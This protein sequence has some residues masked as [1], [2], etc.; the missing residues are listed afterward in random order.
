MGLIQIMNYQISYQNPLTHYIDIALQLDNIVDDITYLQLPT[1]RP[2]RYEL[3]NYANNVLKIEVTDSNNKKVLCRKISHS[4][5][6]IATKGL[7]SITVSYSYYAYVMDGGGS[8]LDEEQ[9]YLNFINCMIYAEGQVQKPCIIEFDLPIDY[10]IATSLK[11]TSKHKLQ[12]SSYYELVDSPMI[13]SATLQKLTY[14]YNDTLF[15]IWIK[16]DH[17]ANID[18]LIQDFKLFTSKQF[19]LFG[20]FPFEKYHFLIQ[21]LPY[22]H[23]HGV[24]HQSSTVIT[25]GPGNEF[26]TKKMY[27][28]LVGISSHELF[29]TWNALKIRPKELMP[30]N[31]SKEAYFDTGYVLEGFTTYYGDLILVRSGVLSVKWY[32]NKL[33]MMLRR[34]YENFGR[35][36]MSV[37]ESSIDLWLDGYTAGIPNRKTSIYNE[38]ALFA[39]ILDLKL[40]QLSENQQSLDDVMRLLWKRHGVADTGYSHDDIISIAHEIVPYNWGKF[41]Y[42]HVEGTQPIEQELGT[43]IKSVGCSFTRFESKNHIE[44]RYGFR[45]DDNKVVKIVPSSIAEL[46]LSLDDVILKINGN[47]VEL[48]Q[49]DDNVT[50]ELMRNGKTRKVKLNS[51]ED[52]YFTSYRIKLD[53]IADEKQKQALA[54]WLT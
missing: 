34:Y 1:W 54:N 52:R 13:A 28:Y 48:Y 9:L 38:G 5:W 11:E 19:A 26:G 27:E 30:Y 10:N 21:A 7:N 49:P 42:E 45:L 31:F 40:R 18:K 24:E 14:S 23:Y 29:H 46:Y 37:M 50:I 33:N 32:L 47:E 51:N 6:E 25:V 41:F 43:L 53:K 3:A 20:A 4:K 15:N 12:A 8:W 22:K 44:S 36:N 2:G 39:L 35:N 17:N 16:G